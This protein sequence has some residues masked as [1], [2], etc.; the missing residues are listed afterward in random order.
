MSTGPRPGR[1][2]A[3]DRIVLDLLAEQAQ[4]WM[5][6]GSCAEVAV[7][8]GNDPWFAER[9][10]SG[11]TALAQRIC[12]RCPVQARCLEFALDGR[13]EWGVWGATTPWQ[14]R[15]MRRGAA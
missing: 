8:P 12:A 4:D 1:P 11:S 9:G 7:G 2:S 5:A 15:R 6:E 13:I 3:E 10:Q 14:R